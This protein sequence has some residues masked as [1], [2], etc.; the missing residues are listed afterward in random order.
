MPTLAIG[1][2]VGP[3]VLQ[4]SHGV[5][6]SE[7]VASAFVLTKPAGGSPSILTTSLANA[8]VGTAYSQTLNA[9]GGSPPYAWSIV[10]ATP[11]YGLW[12]Y[13]TQAG[14]LIGTPQTTETETIIVQVTDATGL[15]SQATLSMAV[16][17]TGSLP[18]SPHLCRQLLLMGFSP[19]SCWHKAELRPMSGR[20][21][22]PPSPG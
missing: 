6:S 19:I 11:N 7:S 12:L 8:T 22:R 15:S 20:P 4:A 10:S 3:D 16:N 14:V 18:L 1:F 17:V 21:P 9:T 5:F 2:N 13:V